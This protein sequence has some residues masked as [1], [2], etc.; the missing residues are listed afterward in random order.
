VR[1]SAPNASSLPPG[2]SKQKTYY[3]NSKTGETV[4]EMPKK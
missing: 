2:N 3:Y 1:A 4:W